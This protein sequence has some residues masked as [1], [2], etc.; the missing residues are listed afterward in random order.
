MQENT[1]VGVSGQIDVPILAF[2]DVTQ[3]GE[4]ETHARKTAL[5]QHLP[6]GAAGPDQPPRR[7]RQPRECAGQEFPLARDTERQAVWP[8]TSTSNTNST[9]NCSKYTQTGRNHTGQ[10]RY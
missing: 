5:T 6:N 3:V 4:R 10:N 9:P 2:I 1:L 8:I 7:L